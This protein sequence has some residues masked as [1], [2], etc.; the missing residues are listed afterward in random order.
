MMRRLIIS[1]AWLALS[2]HGA[3]PSTPT[4]GDA[5]DSDATDA[6]RST[7]PVVEAPAPTEP[8]TTVRVVPPPAAPAPT[9]SANPLWA[10]PLTQLSGTRDRPIFSSS[11]RPPPVAAAAEPVVVRPPPRPK[12]AELP[13]LSLVGT[14]A[15]G[16]D[17]FGIFIDQSSKAALR[18]KVGEDHQGWMLRKIRGRE[19]T[20]EKD[21]QTAVLAL[22]K[23]GSGQSNGEVH[24]VPVRAMTQR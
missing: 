17:G 20:M 2:V 12:E 1:L 18:L 16:D 8:V 14:I 21:R 10:I 23:P 13:Q 11:R 6:P 3:A 5:L 15:V 4:S 22:P 9:L 19:V 24:L 7:G